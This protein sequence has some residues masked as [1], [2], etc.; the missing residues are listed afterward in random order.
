MKHSEKTR[1]QPMDIVVQV[2]SEE[3]VKKLKKLEILTNFAC[4]EPDTAISCFIHG[5]GHRYTHFI[6]TIPEIL[7][8]LKPRD[9]AIDI[10]IKLLLEVYAF[11]PT[12]RVLFPFPAKSGGMG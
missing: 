1:K 12:E 10:F 5:L 2:L 7:H 9:D 8:L 3:F 4:T 11:N 6:G